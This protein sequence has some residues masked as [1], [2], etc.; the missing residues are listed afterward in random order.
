[1]GFEYELLKWF[2]KEHQLTLEIKLVE[3]MDSVFSALNNYEGDIIAANLTVTKAR[4]EFVDFA[5]PHL[6]TKQVLVQ[7]LPNEFWKLTYQQIQE[8]LIKEPLDLE[9]ETVVVR[10][11]SS[12]Y[13]RLKSLSDEIGGEI[14]IEPAEGN[15]QTEDLIALVADGTLKFTIA[16]EN[17][18]KINKKFHPNIDINTPISFEQK[19]AWAIRKGEPVFLDT[20][21]HWIENAKRTN[22]YHTIYTK[23]FRARTV[24]AGKVQSNFNSKNGNLSVFDEIIKENADKI[25][26]DWRL[27][28]SMIFQESQ[29]DTSAESWIGAQGLMQLLPETAMEFGE[30]DLS[31]PSF[32]IYAG[33]QYLKKLDD[34]WSAKIEDSTERKKF[35]LASYNVG[36]GHVLDAERLAIKYNKQ[37]KVWDD[38]VE[39]MLLKKAKKELYTDPESKY[40]YCRGSEPV[41]YVK[42]VMERYHHYQNLIPL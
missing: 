35:V 5:E 20:L 6:T 3:D 29:F 32:N 42:Q 9:N 1:M 30:G 7:R 40:G 4:K 41:N 37:S 33:C 34:Y 2:A 15:L 38:S 23:Y 17:I 25:G 14:N 16:D 31:D 26:W 11:N 39:E 28:A 22:D 36:L 12:F 13:D 24:F 10:R 21:N 27:I 8:S 19:I 18:A